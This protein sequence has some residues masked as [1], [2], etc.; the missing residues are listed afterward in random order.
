MFLILFV[1]D[2]FEFLKLNKIP[3]P[4]SL[5]V[6][7]RVKQRY[8]QLQFWISNLFLTCPKVF[9]ITRKTD[10]KKKFICRY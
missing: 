3:F 7:S 2:I 1:I 5:E 6:S 8:N 4:M 9:N 10:N